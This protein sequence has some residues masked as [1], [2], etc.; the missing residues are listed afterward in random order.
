VA[1]TV[2]VIRLQTLLVE[3]AQV[4]RVDDAEL[5]LLA[6]GCNLLQMDIGKVVIFGDNTIFEELQSQS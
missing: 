6:L 4:P 5:M 1:Q 2:E 3:A